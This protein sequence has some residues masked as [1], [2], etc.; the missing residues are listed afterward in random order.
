V[1]SEAPLSAWR[2]EWGGADPAGAY[3]RFL[4]AGLRAAP[5]WPFREAF[6]GW[7]PGS[8][9]FVAR[10]RGLAGA[11]RSDPP[12]PE[13]RRL[14]GPDPKAI[15]EAVRAHD[16]LDP[17]ELARRGD[18]HLARAA[19]AWLCRRNCEVPLHELAPR[20]GCP[21]LTA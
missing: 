11:V 6:G 4:A 17:T 20:L 15:F 12:A 9:R 2:G 5:P 18:P 8:D 3:R 19:A 10:P 16:G 13:A 21:G 1:A 14:A 7:A